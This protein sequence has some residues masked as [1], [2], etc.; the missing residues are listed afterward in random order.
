MLGH[1]TVL[2]LMARG[3]WHK[4]RRVEEPNASFLA[5]L[6]AQRAKQQ[7]KESVDAVQTPP[8]VM[9]GFYYDPLLKKYFR[10]QAPKRNDEKITKK[11]EING[12]VRRR[13]CLKTIVQ[14]EMGCLQRND[15]VLTML[16]R[17]TPERFQ[18]DTNI[19]QVIDIDVADEKIAIADCNGSIYVGQVNGKRFNQEY[20]IPVHSYLPLSRIK[21]KSNEKEELL[22]CTSLGGGGVHGFLRVYRKHEL[23]YKIDLNSKR[24]AFVLPLQD[25]W[26]LSWLPHSNS[27]SVGATQGKARAHVVDIDYNKILHGP[28]KVKSDVFSQAGLN[29]GQAVLNGTRSGI[30]W[31]WDFRMNQIALNV[32]PNCPT[33][34]SD[35][36][37]LNDDLSYVCGTSNGNLSRHDLRKSTHAIVNYTNVTS[38]RQYSTRIFLD[39]QQVILGGIQGGNTVCMWHLKSGELLSHA[40]FDV[41]SL[42]SIGM[43]ETFKHGWR[44]Y[45]SCQDQLDCVQ[46]TFGI[47]T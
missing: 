2:L 39:K 44:V 17:Q 35:L 45:S 47:G 5:A 21:W 19:D 40:A 24:Q 46:Y 4:K 28:S 33:S 29:Q 18:I 3:K 14:R 31:L 11:Q 30:V 6:E 34:I 42:K 13:N 43:D 32:P 1:V 16:P 9:K 12:N 26:N 20:T 23:R 10:G 25:A 15:Q 7:E 36:V 37:V 41:S 22:G 38:T 27:I 8:V